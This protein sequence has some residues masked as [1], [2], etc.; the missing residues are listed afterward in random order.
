M[1]RRVSL[2]SARERRLVLLDDVTDAIT[3]R[4]L[5]DIDEPAPYYA[6]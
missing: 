5:Q 1:A 6:I 4:R 3:D 2:A